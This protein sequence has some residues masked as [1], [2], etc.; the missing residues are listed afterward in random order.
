MALTHGMNVEEVRQLGQHL[1]ASKGTIENL[2]RE[3]EGKVNGA[4]WQGPDAT[5]FKT[6]W[7][8]QHRTQLNKIADD[9]HGFGQSALNNAQE[10][11]NV[12]R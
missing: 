9:L 11:E 4:G 1:Q 5:R 12:S 7:W 3:I 2:I 8:P 10:Q 6:E